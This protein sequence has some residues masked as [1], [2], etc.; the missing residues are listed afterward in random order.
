MTLATFQK[1]MQIL[2]LPPSINIIIIL[3]GMLL[4]LYRK[5]I[6]WSVVGIG[7]LSLWL[8]ATPFV[9]NH[10]INSLQRHLEQK[11][12]PYQ[13]QA[14]VVLGGGVIPKYHTVNNQP[15]LSATS[16][17][18]LRSAVEL[19]RRTHLPLLLSG[20]G[21]KKNNFA[22]AQLMA[23]ALRRDFNRQPTWYEANSLNT[24]ENGQYTARYLRQQ[25][26][27]TIYL[28]TSAWHI[29]R[30][31]A[32]FESF[33]IQ[34]VPHPAHYSFALAFSPIEQWLP[35]ARALYVSRTAMHELIG[36]IWYEFVYLS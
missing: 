11:A 24:F 8:L 35:K 20:G 30:A 12:K 36:Q 29:P 22:S 4:L 7:I 33:N 23:Q 21:S 2:I 3:L 17:L 15:R 6:G 34:A 18:R 27:D 1:Y 32:V 10:L 14:I 16:W 5:W 13:P 25:H 31:Q 28:V 19:A 9:A 26:I